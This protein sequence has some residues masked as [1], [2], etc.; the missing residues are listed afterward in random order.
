MKNSIG[1]ASDSR[2]LQ[3]CQRPGISPMKTS[4]HQTA[5]SGVVNSIRK[6]APLNCHGNG[7]SN[8]FAQP[9]PTAIANPVAEFR[10]YPLSTPEPEPSAT[11]F[12]NFSISFICEYVSRAASLRARYPEETANGPTSAATARAARAVLNEDPLLPIREP[13]CGI[14]SAMTA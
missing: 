10:S 4:H 13:I 9:I 8:R 6:L 12:L 14:I 5:N 3:T 2:V 11:L 1:C 7:A